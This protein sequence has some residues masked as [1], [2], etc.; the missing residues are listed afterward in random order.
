[1][2]NYQFCL[3]ICHARGAGPTKIPTV[4][5]NQE[6]LSSAPALLNPRCLV[7]SQRCPLA[8]RMMSMPAT[9]VLSATTTHVFGET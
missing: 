5:K 3:V 7:T 8:P 6:C 1:M 2:N 4:S 9:K